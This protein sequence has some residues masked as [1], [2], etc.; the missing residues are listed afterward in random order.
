[1]P[2]SPNLTI[3]QATMGRTAL[4]T[5]ASGYIALHVINFLLQDGWTVHGTVRGLKNAE[6]VKPILELEKSSPGTLQLFEA[7]LLDAGSF[8]ESMQ[9]CDVVIH[10]ASPCLMPEHIKDPQRQL[11]TPALEGTRNVLESVNKTPCVRRVILTSSEGAMRGNANEALLMEN[12][13]VHESYWN[14]ASSISH[15]AY[16][17]SK[18]LAEREAWKM[19]DAQKRWKLVTICPST[20]VGP[21]LT[22]NSASAS[23]DL[24]EQIMNGSMI[25]GVPDMYMP[26]VDV[27]EVALAHVRAAKVSEARGRYILSSHEVTGLLEIALIIR[28]IHKYPWIVPFWKLPDWIVRLTAPLVGVTRRYIDCN[29]GIKFTVDN[30]RSKSELGIEYRS[31]DESLTDHYNQRVLDKL[32]K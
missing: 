29:L 26:M 4:V 11:V 12:H 20:V 17:Y 18:T 30:S 8:L 1:M 9:G 10:I 5:G 23:L 16:A 27:R 6:K 24:I 3:L 14:E 19:A 13:T 21:S 2:V 15:N 7:D 22:P 28:S 32:R 31:L 25:F